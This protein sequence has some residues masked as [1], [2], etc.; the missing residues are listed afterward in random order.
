VHLRV[1]SVGA[2][3]AHRLFLPEYGEFA[4]L[5]ILEAVEY[6]YVSYVSLC[7]KMRV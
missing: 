2:L 1:R 3:E 4:W 7:I 6:V 5:G